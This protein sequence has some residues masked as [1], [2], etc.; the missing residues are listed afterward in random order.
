MSNRLNFP[1]WADAD[2]TST[3]FTLQHLVNGSW[4]DTDMRTCAL[5]AGYTNEVCLN[6]YIEK[7]IKSTAPNL[8]V[9]TGITPQ[10]DAYQIYRMVTDGVETREMGFFNDWS[11]EMYTGNTRCISAPINRHADSRQHLLYGNFAE[12]GNSIIVKELVQANIKMQ[13]TAIT[14]GAEQYQTVTIVVTSN[15]YFELILP[16]WLTASQ[17]A[18]TSGTTVAYLYPQTNTS[19]DSR[20]FTIQAKHDAYWSPDYEY[21]DLAQ[22]VQAGKVAYLTIYP[23]PLGVAWDTTGLTSVTVYT[24]T[25]FTA[26]TNSSDTW[27]TYSGKTEVGTN[28]YN[29]YFNISANTGD[30]R[31]THAYFEYV[32]NSSGGTYTRALRVVQAADPAGT[33]RIYYKASPAQVIDPSV[34][35]GFGA[36]YTGAYNVGSD[37]FWAFETAP[38][39]IPAKACAGLAP[40]RNI[41]APESVTSI[42]YSAFTQTNLTGITAPGVTTIGAYAFNANKSLKNVEFGNLTSIGEYAFQNCSALTSID[43]T[44]I[45]YLGK[46]VFYRCKVLSNVEMGSGITYIPEY[47]FSYCSGLTSMDIPEGVTGMSQYCFYRAN[48]LTAVTLPNT[49]IEIDRTF[50]S[51]AALSSITIPDSVRKITGNFIAGTAITA[52]T[53]P[54]TVEI[55]D[56][57]YLYTTSNLKILIVGAHKVGFAGDR[58]SGGDC[59]LSTLT[60]TTGV[61]EIEDR[62]FL[63]KTNSATTVNYA[64]TKAQWAQVIKGRQWLPCGINVI[65]CSDGDVSTYELALRYVTSDG[66][67]AGPNDAGYQSCFERTYVGNNTYEICTIGQWD[68]PSSA[69]TGC[70]NL[71]TVDMINIVPVTGYTYGNAHK[72]VFSGCTGLESVSNIEDFTVIELYYFCGCTSLSSITL[73]NN[74]WKIAQGAFEDC[75][76]L[77]SITLPESLTSMDSGAFRGSSLSSVTIPDRLATI[78]HQAFYTCGALSSVTIGSG[79]TTIESLAFARCYSLNE[80][81]YNGTVLQWNAISK[82]AEWANESGVSPIPATVVHCTDGDTPI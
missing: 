23:D 24:N 3:G 60:I 65:H 77:S 21:T 26:T 61:T 38:T 18:F 8:N 6:R 2:T 44:H 49:L 7:D 28:Y 12:T 25:D 29:V 51:A 43:L 40:L 67:P 39:A 50:N 68:I 10:P 81:N 31:Q 80:I 63:Y 62:A 82:D 5:P 58:Y 20:Q 47:C 64:G 46:Y 34:T 48:N 75:T 66:L 11:Y 56:N 36:V 70:T 30:N 57:Q 13:P 59:T 72:A 33:V 15:T 19:F 71:K 32:V 1:I 45:E 22:V 9:A 73:G 53:I 52:L 14:I 55:L 69:F 4:V 27:L 76:S 78:P 74:V 54:D 35:E 17:T 42:G 37:Y 41:I 79:V 16:E